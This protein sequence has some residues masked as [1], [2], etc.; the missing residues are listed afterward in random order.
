MKHTRWHARFW[1][2][3]ARISALSG[4]ALGA[5]A[6]IA[7]WTGLGWV[8]GPAAIGAVGAALLAFALFSNLPTATEGDEG[9]YVPNVSG[10]TDSE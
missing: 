8:S 6:I 9:S 7:D 1:R 4:V 3:A 2:R 10:N 5:V